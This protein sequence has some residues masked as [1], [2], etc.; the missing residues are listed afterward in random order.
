MKDTLRI[1]GVYVGTITGA[2]YASG[3]EILQF[4]TGYG[5]WGII[6]TLVTMILYPVLGY[7][8]VVLGKR[9]KAW[10]HKSVI[11]HICGKYLGV[12]VDIL[13]A[14]FLFGVGVIMIAGSGSLFQQQFGIPPVAGYAL[15]TLLVILALLLSLRRVL[16]VISILTPLA[17]GL[18][19][20]LAVYAAL[21][22]DTSGVDLEAVAATQE[23]LASP[24]WLLSA[25]LH[26][27]F[28]VAITVS[29]LAII[30]ATERNYQ[31][32]KRGVVLG[33][34]LLGFIALLINLALYLNVD[35]LVGTDMPMLVI[36]TELHPWIGAAMAVVLLAMIFNTAVP[37]LY[38]FTARFF[39][40]ETR[41]FRI[42]AIIIGIAAFGFGF[43]GFTKLVGTVYP[44]LGYV[45]FVIF[46][47]MAVNLIRTR[48]QPVATEQYAFTDS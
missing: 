22:A 1:A 3:Q 6:G 15:M 23:E 44:L 38:T 12:V 33:G 11:Y 35:D 17:F 2:G 16:N 8:L 18:I 42:A 19:I 13:L 20:V 29:I 43:I 28:N 34:I 7:Y 4:F 47:S 25:F 9:V 36:A 37:T 48:R 39:T 30:G 46:I 24:H 5:W 10:S 27:S 32:A 21:T 45:G 40:V 26:V 31:A 41:S 14:F